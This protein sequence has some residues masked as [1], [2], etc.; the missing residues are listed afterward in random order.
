MS[1][2]KKTLDKLYTD[3]FPV[4]KLF[5]LRNNGSIEDAEDIFQE[6]MMV[7]VEK[8]RQDDFVL[9]ASLK[10]YVMA[11][12]KNLW[13]K[14]LRDAKKNSTTELTDV[15][16]SVLMEEITTAIEV[17]K[18]YWDKLNAYLF[19][20]SSHC[21]TILEMFYFEKKTIDEIQKHFGY[22]TKHNAQN[23]KYKCVEQVK[24]VKEKDNK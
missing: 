17:E 22:S 2:Q 21:K 12:A 14:Q 3:Y 20:V 13:F 24:A 19:S 10:T 7:L 9:S 8:L 11:I 18:T 6:A 15:H 4:F 23:Q 5:V 1:S 16:S